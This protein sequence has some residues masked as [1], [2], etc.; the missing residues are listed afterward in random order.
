[1][2]SEDASPLATDER[3][4][5]PRYERTLTLEADQTDFPVLETL[6]VSAGGALCRVDR[7]LEPMTR[8]RVVTEIPGNSAIEADAVVVRVEPDQEI[9]GRDDYR[10]ALF[11][12]KMEEEDRQ[13]LCHWLEG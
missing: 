7:W 1:M 9:P 13:A 10:V 5:H 2:T 8:L 3:R 12:Q 6:N 11:F 4:A